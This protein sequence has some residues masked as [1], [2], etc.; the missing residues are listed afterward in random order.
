[1]GRSDIFSL[2]NASPIKNPAG[3]KELLETESLRVQKVD[4]I[5]RGISMVEAKKWRILYCDAENP[6]VE[7]R[8]GWRQETTRTRPV[9]PPV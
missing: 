1:M 4:K 8:T 6:E 9:E 2:D 5:P 7:R 3:K